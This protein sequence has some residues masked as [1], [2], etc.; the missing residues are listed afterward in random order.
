[1]SYKLNLPVSWHSHTD[2]IRKESLSDRY[3]LVIKEMSL[4]R[5]CNINMNMITE[6]EGEFTLFH[7]LSPVC[8]VSHSNIKSLTV[9]EVC[10]A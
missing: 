8:T 1:M 7:C 6:E 9:K 2:Y 5:I 4:T 3:W 10:G